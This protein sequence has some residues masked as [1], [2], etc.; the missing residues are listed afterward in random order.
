MLHSG[1]LGICS[2]NLATITQQQERMQPKYELIDRVCK[3]ELVYKVDCNYNIMEV[4]LVKK[5][6]TR[7]YYNLSQLI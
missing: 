2:Q 1:S 7:T 3:E 6:D 5:K 4:N